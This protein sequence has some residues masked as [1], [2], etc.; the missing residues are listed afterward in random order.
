MAL[1][2]GAWVAKVP[3][4]ALGLLLLQAGCDRGP[5]ATPHPVDAGVTPKFLAVP[6]DVGPPVLRCDGGLGA[7]ALQLPCLL[8][9]APESEVDCGLAGAPAD[10]KI[11]FL[12]PLSLPDQVGGSGVA[13]GEP[14]RFDADLLPFGASSTLGDGKYT[15]RGITGT[16]VFTELSP[17][18]ATL[19]GWFPHLDFVWGAADG[20]TVT[21]A[22]DKGRFTA[23]PGGFI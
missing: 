12:L 13:L 3:L 2:R 14:A 15:P 10:Q 7:V 11:R 1:D 8:G 4:G 18:D 23:I 6:A 16:V 19:D 5:L 22:V 17:A 9:K 20:S 21:C